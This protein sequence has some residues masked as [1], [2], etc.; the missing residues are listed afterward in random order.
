MGR[1]QRHP[2]AAGVA[3]CR[4]A[5]VHERSGDAAS[6]R[7]GVDA[8]HADVRLTVL[9]GRVVVVDALAQ[10]ERRGAD[11]PVVVFGFV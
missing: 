5:R 10:L 1:V 6:A 4:E 2:C 11:D 8:E 3:C 7:L 9:E